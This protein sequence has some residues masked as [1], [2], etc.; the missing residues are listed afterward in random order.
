MDRHRKDGAAGEDGGNPQRTCGRRFIS[1]AD[2]QK[3]YGKSRVTIWRWVRT[4]RLPA[5]F[6]T[7]PNSVDFD[8]DEI[9]ARDANLERVTYAPTQE[10][11]T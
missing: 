8:A 2:L 7:G 9:E 5:P 1:Y 4:G 11:V 6:R 10:A 3:R